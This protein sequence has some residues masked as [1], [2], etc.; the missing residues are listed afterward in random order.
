M[1]I[2]KL[3]LGGAV[4]YRNMTGAE[5]DLLTN[6]KK[7]QSG[8]AIDEILANCTEAIGSVDEAGEFHPDREFIR[9]ED[10]QRLKTPDRMALLLAVRRESYG[11]ELDVDLRCES[12]EQDFSAN[13]DLSQVEMKP[14]PEDYD[15]DQGFEVEVDVDGKPTRIRF[16]YMTGNHERMLAKQKDNLMT[17]AMQARLREVE[18]VNRND[19]RRWLLNLPVTARRDLRKMM[20]ETDCGPVMRRTVDCPYCGHEHQ[21]NAHHA[22]GF[23]FPEE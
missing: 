10:I 12:C 13:I 1:P 18:G 11:D 6:Q 21:I 15:P 2:L 8:E 22:P 9:V 16:D 7:F 23:F 3:P 5:E 14:V 17:A 20:S 4:K 19:F